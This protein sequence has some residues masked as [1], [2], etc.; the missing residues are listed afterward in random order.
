MAN[1]P[2][3]VMIINSYLLLTIFL[4][5]VYSVTAKEAFNLMEGRAVYKQLYNK[6]EGYHASA[7][8]GQ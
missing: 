5:N 8:T 1:L 2:L 6:G 3:I 4:S 7:P